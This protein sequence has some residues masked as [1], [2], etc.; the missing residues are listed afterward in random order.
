VSGEE[1]LQRK[2]RRVNLAMRSMR[3]NKQKINRSIAK[4][5]KNKDLSETKDQF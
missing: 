4:I 3:L 5:A 1:G 2:I